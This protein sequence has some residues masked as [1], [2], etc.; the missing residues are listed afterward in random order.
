MCEKRDMSGRTQEE[1]QNGIKIIPAL[2]ET[3]HRLR[4]PGGCPWDRAQTHQ[5]LRQY[6]IEEAYEVLDCLDRIDSPENLKQEANRAPFQEELGDLLMQVL[7]HSEMANEVGAFDI[8][9]VARGL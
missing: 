6:L 3:V 5:S 8:F 2:I 1:T 4:A 7:L 9:D